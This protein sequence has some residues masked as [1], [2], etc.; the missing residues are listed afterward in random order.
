MKWQK[1][2]INKKIGV[3]FIDGP[4]DY[5]SQ[6]ISLIKYENLMSD[7]SIIIIDDC[8]YYHVRKATQD[9]LETHSDYSLVFQKYTNKHVAN[10]K[11]DKSYYLDGYWN[12]INV[13]YKSKKNK[14]KKKLKMQ[15]NETYLKT[16]FYK[17]HEMFR[18]YYS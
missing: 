15:K 14:F 8:N 2:L 12:G 16:L 11:K 1:K 7:N 4:H 6:L 10:E 9:F 5:R 13:L 17:S 18:H 3:L